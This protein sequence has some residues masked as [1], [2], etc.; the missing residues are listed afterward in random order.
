MAEYFAMLYKYLIGVAGVMAGVIIVIAGFQWLLAAGDAGKIKHAKERISGALIGLILVLGS[1]TVLYTINPDLVTFKN[2]KIKLVQYEEIDDVEDATTPDDEGDG[3][4]PDP[5]CGIGWVNTRWPENQRSPITQVTAQGALSRSLLTTQFNQQ[6]LL[7]AAQVMSSLGLGIR[8]SGARS[9]N[10]QINLVKKRCE[11]SELKRNYVN[12]SVATA[13]NPKMWLGKDQP[14]PAY[15][16]C[17]H[18]NSLDLFATGPGCGTCPG[19]TTSAGRLCWATNEC[20]IK[21]IGAML[22]SGYGVL[23]DTNVCSKAFEPW[24]FNRRPE[25]GFQKSA[26]GDIATVLQKSNEALIKA[27]LLGGGC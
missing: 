8:G 12:C 20:Q 27:S 7:K 14:N 5:L 22:A 10:T 9:M 6:P 1:Y 25:G 13:S 4:T 17:T 11:W 16:G 2:L 24:H 21:L 3:G 19:I 18:V 26:T 23:M 15:A